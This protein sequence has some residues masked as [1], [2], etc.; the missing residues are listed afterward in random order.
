MSSRTCHCRISS[1]LPGYVTVYPCLRSQHGVTYFSQEL[2]LNRCVSK[3][4][5]AITLRVWSCKRKLNKHKNSASPFF[6]WLTFLWETHVF[7][8]LQL[9]NQLTMVP[10]LTTVPWNLSFNQE[11][12]KGS[13]KIKVYNIKK[14]KIK[15]A[16]FGLWAIFSL[17]VFSFLFFYRLAQGHLK[18]ILSLQGKAQNGQWKNKHGFE[19][20]FAS[21]AA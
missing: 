8:W 18:G 10:S 6:A 3:K 12:K 15:A 11:T 14:I 21:N 2:N 19:N 4:V 17:Y 20:C 13:L 1:L 9:Q 16:Y 7:L 5:C